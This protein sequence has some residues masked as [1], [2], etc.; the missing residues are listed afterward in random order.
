MSKREDL[1]KRAKKQVCPEWLL[2]CICLD[3]KKHTLVIS[4]RACNDR[5]ITSIQITQGKFSS[6]TILNYRI[7]T[8]YTERKKDDI[9][10]KSVNSFRF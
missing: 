7:K 8:L 10:K 9:Y 1:I 6:P 4:P 2:D 5:G 3:D